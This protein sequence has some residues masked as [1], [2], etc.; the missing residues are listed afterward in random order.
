MAKEKI[1]DQGICNEKAGFLFKHACLRPPVTHCENCS[2]PICSDHM[3]QHDSRSL[4]I[5][6][7]QKEAGSEGYL[8]RSRYQQ[9]YHNDPYFYGGYHY[10][11]Y[12][13]YDSDHGWGSETYR[14]RTQHRHDE[15]DFTEADSES[16]TNQAAGE[17][18]DDIVTAE[19][20]DGDNDFE[21]DMSES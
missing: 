11:G 20:A 2:K 12:G 4:C 16:L 13:M 17:V 21:N 1:W 19:F 9:T 8:D 5:K 18:D 15:H 7:A 3:R 14:S 10:N 6:C